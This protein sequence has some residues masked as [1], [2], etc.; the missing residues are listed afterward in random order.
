MC[1]KNI[2][3][4]ISIN[5]KKITM[6]LYVVRAGVH[7]SANQVIVYVNVSLIS[8][9]YSVHRDLPVGKACITINTNVNN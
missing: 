3:Y 8:T 2:I 6:P 7:V 4:C 5:S 9:M 1:V